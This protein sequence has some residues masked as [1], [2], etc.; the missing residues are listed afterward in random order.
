MRHLAAAFLL[1]VSITAHAELT[2][3][4]YLNKSHED[5]ALQAY[6]AG[7]SQAFGWANVSL[8][9]ANKEM[10]FCVPP[11]LALNNENVYSILDRYIAEDPT[12][13]DYPL[14]MILL[15][16]LKKAFPCK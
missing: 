2:G 12:S 7:L 13:R 14:G 4:A 3:T 6:V 9:R 16:A 11:A 15:E 8:H 1:L 5:P 10:L